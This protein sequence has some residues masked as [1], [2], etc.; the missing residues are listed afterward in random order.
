VLTTEAEWQIYGRVWQRP[1]GKLGAFA[2]L[3]F[4]RSGL[5]DLILDNSR[6][7]IFGFL[8][9]KDQRVSLILNFSII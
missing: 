9:F 1:V 8:R 2:A 7:A 4:D 5:E 6:L 3:L